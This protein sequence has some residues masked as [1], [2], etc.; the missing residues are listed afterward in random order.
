MPFFCSAAKWYNMAH[1]HTLKLSFRMSTLLGIWVMICLA[2]YG[3]TVV[4]IAQSG[5]TEAPKSKQ[6]ITG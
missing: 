2:L 6:M 1:I 3:G 4:C 5:A